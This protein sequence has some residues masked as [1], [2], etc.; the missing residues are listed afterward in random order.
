MD[1]TSSST[2]TDLHI[3]IEKKNNE[4]SKFLKLFEKT[5]KEIKYHDENSNDFYAETFLPKDLFQ[6]CNI[7]EEEEK[8]EKDNFA[9]FNNKRNNIQIPIQQQNKNNLEIQ[10]KMNFFGTDIQI[11]IKQMK[12]YRGSMYLQYLLTLL[13]DYDIEKLLLRLSPNLTEM[14]C[15][16][17]GNYFIQKLFLRLNYQQRLFIFNLIQNNF[18]DICIDKSGTYSI[19]ALIDSIKTP[20]EEKIMEN[21]LNKNLL[22]LFY[23]ENS[24]HIIQKIIIDYPEYK[25]D[26][27]NNF[28]LGNLN[29]ICTNLY[30]SLC[31]IKFIIMN[32]NLFIRL[33]LIKGIQ[34]IFFNLV[35]NR[36]GCSIIFF[37]LEKYGI[38]YCYFIIEF[39][40]QNFEFLMN[41]PNSLILIEKVLSYVYKYVNNEFND[42]VW[43]II[44]NEK[45]LQILIEKEPSNRI[46]SFINKT[47]SNEQK[48]MFRKKLKNLLCKDKS[49][50]EKLLHLIVN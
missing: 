39:I 4:S 10:A 26:F 11:L 37:L 49:L 42:I 27:L 12:S 20:F 29:K 47:L 31:L 28:I 46:L 48:D 14:M 9:I 23:N 43:M 40:K 41:Q 16:H 17:Y 5:N 44:K 38:E 3:K 18:V 2:S 35:L 21:L 1:Q 32:N 30:G 22:L 6:D 33:K 19:Q 7:C 25:R 45:I 36:Y 13:D 34:C 8:N 50:K 24:H 15:S